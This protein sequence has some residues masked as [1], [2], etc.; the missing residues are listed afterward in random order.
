MN[1][2]T[3]KLPELNITALC[4]NYNAYFENKMEFRLSLEAI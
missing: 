2:L 1:N 4:I 3:W